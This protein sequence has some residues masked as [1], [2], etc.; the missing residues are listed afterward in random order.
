MTNELITKA[1]ECKSA[2]ELFALAKESNVEMTETQAAELFSKL[3]QEGELSDDEL[4][5]AAG[6]GS[7]GKSSG[8]SPKNG[9][10]VSVVYDSNKC[11]KCGGMIG[12]I[13]NI[14][15]PGIGCIDYTLTCENAACGNKKW[16]INGLVEDNGFI[17][18]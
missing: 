15:L 16:V 6:G 7:C 12:V 1:K 4:D 9:D 8:Y 13:T 10:R 11:P 14:E 17:P 5:S 2:E 18:A 3:N